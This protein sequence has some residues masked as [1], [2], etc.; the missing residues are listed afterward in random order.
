MLK[1]SLQRNQGRDNHLRRSF[2]VGLCFVCI[3]H[4]RGGCKSGRVQPAFP[5]IHQSPP[6][7]FGAI[8]PAGSGGASSSRSTNPT[9]M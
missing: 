7:G 8:D 4:A 3:G 6:L 9:S 2:S 1:I 5:G